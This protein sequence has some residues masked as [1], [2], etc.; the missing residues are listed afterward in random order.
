MAAHAAQNTGL[1]GAIIAAAI[2]RASLAMA[3][4]DLDGVIGA[5]EAVRATGRPESHNL[6]RYDW[7]P[8]EVNALIAMGRLGQAEKALAELEAG[9]PSAAPPSAMVTAARLRGELAIAAGCPAAAAEAFQTAWRHAQDLQVPLV[10]AQLEIS[11]GRRLCASGQL[12]AAAAQLR[13]ARQRLITLGARPYLQACDQELAAAGA[14]A[15]AE[16]AL[17]P[18]GPYP[19]RAGSGPPGRGRPLQPANR[20]RTVRQH[21][22]CGIP[23]Q[24][25]LRQARHPIPQRPHQPH[26]PS[27]APGRSTPGSS[28]GPTAADDPRGTRTTRYARQRLRRVHAPEPYLGGSRA[29]VATSCCH[30]T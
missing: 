20:G 23:P 5:A 12:R 24:A 25:H 26:R 19:S 15:G 9:L 2:A 16:P 27:L 22:D 13:A 18:P 6:G 30:R 21:Q 10:R 14:P 7:R 8:L 3:Q 11:D 29:T 1:P 17:F 28:P 4:G